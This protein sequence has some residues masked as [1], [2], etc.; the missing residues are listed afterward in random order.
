MCIPIY[1]VLCANK[2][3]KACCGKASTQQI[4]GKLGSLGSLRVP[5]RQKIFARTKVLSTLLVILERKRFTQCDFDSV[6]F[7]GRPIKIRGRK[8]KKPRA[9]IFEARVLGGGGV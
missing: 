9:K 8:V 3:K 4:S 6:Q 7:P 2:Q 5:G 1:Q